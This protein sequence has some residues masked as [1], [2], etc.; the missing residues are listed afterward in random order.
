MQSIHADIAYTL[1]EYLMKKIRPNSKKIIDMNIANLHVLK[2]LSCPEEDEQAS[3]HPSLGHDARLGVRG[4]L[5]GV[6]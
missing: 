2:G 3:V 6:A 5:P 1:G 4:R